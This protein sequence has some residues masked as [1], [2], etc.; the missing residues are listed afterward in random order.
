V[1]KLRNERGLRWPISNPQGTEPCFRTT[2]NRAVLAS[3]SATSLETALPDVLYVFIL[4]ECY[5]RVGHIVSVD[6][7]WLDA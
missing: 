3:F 1:K 5:I 7:M 4:D 2:L 6:V